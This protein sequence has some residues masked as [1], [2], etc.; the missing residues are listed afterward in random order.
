MANITF[1]SPV[2]AKD[3]TVYAVA[4][5]RGSILS[6][7][8]AYKIP[9]PFDCG[10]GECGSCLIEVTRLGEGAK[11]G[12]TMQE[13]EKEMLRQLGKVTPAEIE[14]AET[15]DIPPRFRLACQFIVRE[16]DILVCFDGD[17]TLPAKRPAMSVAAADFTGGIRMTSVEMFLGHAIKVE[18][19]AASHFD[20][21]GEA[22]EDR[23]NTEV[24]KL[25]RQL[26]GY[27]RLHLQAAKDRAGSMD[28]SA[29][30]P[31]EH[32]WP[33][34]ETPEQTSLWAGDAAM[35]KRDA[36]K[37]AL[38]GEK[39]G[40]EFY[41]HI[42]STAGDK[43]IRAL[44]KEFATEEAEHVAILERWIAGEE[45]MLPKLETN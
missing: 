30:L 33:E 34:F 9:I 18:E 17:E 45:A 31:G 19:E 14:N 44:A 24:A 1:R 35:S 26:A 42:A 13:K 37:A 32:V 7:A 29:H 10:D 39:N 21:L 38:Q 40:F 22:M 25:F 23:G 8:K 12:M 16:E 43:E 28:V 11:M 3:V 27:S 4:G 41:H 20:E 6:L 15:N 36:L 2:M 5:A